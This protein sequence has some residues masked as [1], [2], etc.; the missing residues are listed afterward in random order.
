MV[1]YF[2]GVFIYSLYFLWCSFT[3]VYGLLL[4]S[5]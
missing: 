5:F 4:W 3:L 1:G 2:N